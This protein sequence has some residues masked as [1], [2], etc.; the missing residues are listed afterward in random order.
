[1]LEFVCSFYQLVFQVIY[2]DIYLPFYVLKY[3]LIPADRKLVMSLDVTPL[4]SA[5]SFLKL[6]RQYCMICM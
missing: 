2:W 5:V 6:I 4:M 1:M 3:Q